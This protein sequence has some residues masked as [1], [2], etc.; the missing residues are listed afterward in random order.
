[1]EQ[2]LG[3]CEAL[4]L[5]H[6]TNKIKKKMQRLTDATLVGVWSLGQS[7]SDL[8]WLRLILGLPSFLLMNTLPAEGR[9]FPG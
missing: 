8:S 3:M 4:G 7:L 6:S 9:S 2:V 5:I 1:M